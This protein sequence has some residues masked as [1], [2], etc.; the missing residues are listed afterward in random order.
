VAS[1]LEQ[2]LPH[3]ADRIAQAKAPSDMSI[4]ELKLALKH[5]GLGNK[6]TTF[7]EKSEFVNL[8]EQYL[9]EAR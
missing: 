9:N 3:D 7:V 1:Y 5:A 6:I 2:R 4:K 8:L